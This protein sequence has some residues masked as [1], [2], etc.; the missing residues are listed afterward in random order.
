MI[1]SSQKINADDLVERRGAQIDA[2]IEL[3]SRRLKPLPGNGIY[4]IA[5][6]PH[7]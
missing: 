1:A 3:L 2:A 4:A 7:E 5:D 6:W